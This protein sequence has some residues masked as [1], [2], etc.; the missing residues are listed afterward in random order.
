M[1]GGL[2]NQL[3]QYFRSPHTTRTFDRILRIAKKQ[4]DFGYG[5]YGKYLDPEDDYDWLMMAEEELVDLTKYLNAAREARDIENILFYKRV[6]VCQNLL[7]EAS[8]GKMEKDD[9][10]KALEREMTTMRT[11][12]DERSKLGTTKS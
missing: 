4:D 8:S 6:L 9:V 11:M 3:H 5:K 12:L 7:K 2:I 10:L 1:M